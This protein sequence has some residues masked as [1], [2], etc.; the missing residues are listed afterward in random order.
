MREVLPQVRGV[1]MLAGGAAAPLPE[2]EITFPRARQ[3]RMR[4][5]DAAPVLAE[6]DV[7]RREAPRS[8]PRGHKLR[9]KPRRAPDDVVVADEYGDAR[10]RASLFEFRGA[11]QIRSAQRLLDQDRLGRFGDRFARKWHV[12]CAAACR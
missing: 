3:P 2:T 9:R 4:G 10:W 6:F 8:P 12:D 11:R 1:R 7:Q 5:E